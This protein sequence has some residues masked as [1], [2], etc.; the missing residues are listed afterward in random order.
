MRKALIAITCTVL[1]AGCA[2]LPTDQQID[3]ANYGPYPENYK[4][5]VEAYYDKELRDPDATLWRGIAEPK[6]YWIGNEMDNV[7]YGYLVC[8]TLNTKNL[9]GG[10]KGYTT[11][12]LMINN[13]KVIKFVADGDWWGE[14]LCD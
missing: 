12:A 13:G 14:K 6:R 5:I 3:N 8:A 7:Y 10:Y 4:A 9:F 11:D 2:D 1:T